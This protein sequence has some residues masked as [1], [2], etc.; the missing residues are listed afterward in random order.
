MKVC[1]SKKSSNY[2]WTKGGEEICYK[3]SHV[4]RQSQMT[5]NIPVK[6]YFMMSFIYEFNEKEDKVF[7]SYSFPYDFSKLSDFI[8]NQRLAVKS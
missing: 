1:I 3:S 7:F 4:M 2:I 5:Q 8:N 6:P